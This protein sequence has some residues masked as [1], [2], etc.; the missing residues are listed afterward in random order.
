MCF[1]FHNVLHGKKILSQT[2]NSVV[3]TCTT[4]CSL[5][6]FAIGGYILECAEY[7][8]HNLTCFVVKI[9]ILVALVV[10]NH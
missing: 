1:K 5:Q 8:C 4:Q 10:Y 2:H 9:I 7:L 3:G 6:D